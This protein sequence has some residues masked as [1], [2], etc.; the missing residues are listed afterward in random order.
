[1]PSAIFG[2]TDAAGADRD[3]NAA[4]QTALAGYRTRLRLAVR[5]IEE[6]GEL[7]KTVPVERGEGLLWVYLGLPPWRTTSEMGWSFD[8]AERFLAAQARQAV[9]RDPPTPTEPRP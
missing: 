5:R 3:I 9:L 1:M 8:R 6:L 2:S 4:L 7:N